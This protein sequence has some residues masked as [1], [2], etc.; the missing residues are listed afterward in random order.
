MGFLLLEKNF[1][2]FESN[3]IPSRLSFYNIFVVFLTIKAIFVSRSSSLEDSS[4]TWILVL[5][6]FLTRFESQVFLLEGRPILVID[7]HIHF[8]S[9]DLSQYLSWCSGEKIQLV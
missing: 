8:M 1:C 9:I 4:S 3:F 5:P 7:V 6:F 2:F